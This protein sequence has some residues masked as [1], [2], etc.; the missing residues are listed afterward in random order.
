MAAADI[1]ADGEVVLAGIVAMAHELKR[2]V[3]AEGVESEADAQ[4]LA[5]IG[6]RIRPGLLF[7]ARRSTAPRHWITSPGIITSTAAPELG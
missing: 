6:L 4:F 3:V 2:A 7:F 1:D 5:E